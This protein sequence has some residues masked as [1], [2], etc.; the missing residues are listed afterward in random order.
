MMSFKRGPQISGFDL[1]LFNDDVEEKQFMTQYEQVNT[2]RIDATKR[3][4][5]LTKAV[6][7]ASRTL[8]CYGPLQPTIHSLGTLLILRLHNSFC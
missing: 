4:K 5:S 2:K 6:A 1:S 8:L 3:K 7:E